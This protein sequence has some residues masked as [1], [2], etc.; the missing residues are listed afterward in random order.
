MTTATMTG[1]DWRALQQGAD[2]VL[3][4]HA[5]MLN[6]FRDEMM[7]LFRGICDGR[8][9]FKRKPNISLKLIMAGEPPAKLFAL[10]SWNGYRK[11]LDCSKVRCEMLT[12][13][14]FGGGDRRWSQQAVIQ[15]TGDRPSLSLHGET[16][17]ED[18]GRIAATVG[19]YLDD[20][21]AVLARSCESC[22]VCGRHLTDEL[23][24]GR[25]I[26]PECIQKFSGLGPAILSSIIGAE[27]SAAVDVDDL[28]LLASHVTGGFGLPDDPGPLSSRPKAEG[29]KATIY[30]TNIYG[31]V[32]KDE[33]M[34]LSFEVMPTYAQH[35]DVPMVRARKPR[36]RQTYHYVRDYV[37]GRFLL[38]VEGWG[39]PGCP[40]FEGDTN[41]PSQDREHYG[42]Y[43]RRC[44]ESIRDYCS[45]EGCK[46][47][48]D[49]H[50]AIDA[51]ESPA[52]AATE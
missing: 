37:P 45:E 34:F 42:P 13:R 8:E 3:G 27:S 20:R 15:L 49:V 47:L 14:D 43:L 4:E 36:H 7:E 51:Y 50:E 18:I 32:I 33:A 52:L 41:V 38:V 6:R 46:L 44:R 40:P 19:D 9:S 10:P 12:E 39:C 24:R 2:E 28:G 23:S 11:K 31:E 30:V 17:R 22:C 48:V 21:R 29:V 5:A 1:W 26:G 25:G 16:I 35:R